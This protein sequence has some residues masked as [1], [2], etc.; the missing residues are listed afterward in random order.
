M[1]LE[2][3]ASIAGSAEKPVTMDHKLDFNEVD[4]EFPFPT[5]QELVELRRVTGKIPWVTYAIAFVEFCE[6]FSYYGTTA[7]CQ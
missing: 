2:K 6:R 5:E 1:E 7:V 3:Q 4:D